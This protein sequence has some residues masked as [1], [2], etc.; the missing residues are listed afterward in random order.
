MIQ[1]VF[2]LLQLFC[3]V[4]TILG[5][6]V[7]RLG[8]SGRLAQH[9]RFR[10]MLGARFQVRGYPTTLLLNGQGQEARGCL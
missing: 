4:A 3:C 6:E 8:W 5:F 2:A 9:R 1:E 7:C 10:E